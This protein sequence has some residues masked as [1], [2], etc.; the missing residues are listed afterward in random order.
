M[1]RVATPLERALRSDRATR[2]RLSATT[3]LLVARQLRASYRPSQAERSFATFVDRAVPMIQTAQRAG[4]L[5]AETQARSAGVTSWR[6]YVSPPERTTAGLYATGWKALESGAGLAKAQSA[7]VGAATRQVTIA[8]QQSVIDTVMGS[9]T[10]MAYMLVTGAA[11]CWFC[12]MLA[13]RGPVYQQDSLDESDPRFIGPGTA[14]VHDNCGCALVVVAA[15]DQDQ[16]IDWLELQKEWGDVTGE[17]YGRGKAIAWR[18][19]WT[20]KNPRS[21]VPRWEQYASA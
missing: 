17:F 12:S 18:K 10:R 15:R 4:G 13:S 7:V 2:A 5:L 19:H 11:P 16:M 3:G 21:K 6:P 8:M 14:K 9:R 1:S 20:K